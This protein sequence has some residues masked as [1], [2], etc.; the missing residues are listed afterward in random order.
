[1]KAYQPILLSKTHATVVYIDTSTKPRQM[2]SRAFAAI[3]ASPSPSWIRTRAGV[4]AYLS[5]ITENWLRN[6]ATRGPSR[7]NIASCSTT[8]LG[9]AR[10]TAVCGFFPSEIGS[11]RLRRARCTEAV[12]V[13][14]KHSGADTVN[15]MLTHFTQAVVSAGRG[16]STQT[17]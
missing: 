15:P 4:R 5:N 12:S 13:A 16:W 8:L 3:P 1:M 9:V 10:R 2:I 6:S 17:S 14:N 11:E 7:S